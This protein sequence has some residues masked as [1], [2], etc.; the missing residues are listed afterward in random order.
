MVGE[1]ARNDPCEWALR[2]LLALVGGRFPAV[3]RLKW[4]YFYFNRGGNAV[5]YRPQ[6]REPFPFAEGV[7]LF[8]SILEE[9]VARCPLNNVFVRL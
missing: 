1:N 3:I 8:Q 6:Q 5:Y 4:K 9:S 7:F 2:K